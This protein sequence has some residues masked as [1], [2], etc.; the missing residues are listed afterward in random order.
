MKAQ[1]S[2]KIGIT[3]GGS[4]APGKGPDAYFTGEVRID[5]LFKPDDPLRSSGAKVTFEPGARSAWHTHPYG[6]ILIITAGT[7]WVQQWG[8]TKEEMREGDVVRIPPGIKHWHGAAAG[9]AMA[10]IAI[11]EALDDKAAEWMEKVS[12][13]QY[14]NSQ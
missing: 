1:A 2:R 14:M 3:R 12:D 9:S 11:Q 8:G 5:P 10:H 4:Q 13:E 7:G 6:Q